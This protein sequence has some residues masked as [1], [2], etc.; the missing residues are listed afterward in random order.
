MSASDLSSLTCD[1]THCAVCRKPL[2]KRDVEALLADDDC[3][4]EVCGVVMFVCYSC[5]RRRPEDADV[6]DR[7][8][9]DHCDG[10]AQLAAEQAQIVAAGVD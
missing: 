9:N 6:I 1:Q 8:F 2:P 4:C 3:A 5:R 7:R 10:C